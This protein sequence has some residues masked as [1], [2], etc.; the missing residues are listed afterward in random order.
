MVRRGLRTSI[1][2]VLGIAGQ[3]RE[4]YAERWDSGMLFMVGGGALTHCVLQAHTRLPENTLTAAVGIAVDAAF[5]F[6]PLE[7]LGN[8]A[9]HVRHYYAKAFCAL[10]F[11]CIVFTEHLGVSLF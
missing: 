1:F 7:S 8:C 9:L 2:F 4:F 10:P 5:S 6:F 11:P 3:T